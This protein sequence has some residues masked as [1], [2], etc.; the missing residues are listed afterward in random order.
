MR[1]GKTLIDANVILRYLL[2]DDE[3]M[4]KDAELIM[5]GGAYTLPEVLCEVV[6]VL[7]EVYGMSKRDACACLMMILH[8]VAIEEPRTM[9]QAILAYEEYNLDFVDCILL[10]KN[11]CYGDRVFTFDKGLQRHLG[12]NR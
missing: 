5:A 12:S 7:E 3:R 9:V 10:A 1:A 2:D 11:R 8:V 4:S 6:Y